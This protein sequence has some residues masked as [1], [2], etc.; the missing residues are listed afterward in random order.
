MSAGRRQK[1]LW[2]VD[3]NELWCQNM[4]I[5]ILTSVLPCSVA[6]WLVK[7]ALRT[8]IPGSHVFVKFPSLECG[9][10][11]VTWIEPIQYSQGDEM[12]LPWLGYKTLS[13][14]S[15]WQ[16]VFITFSTC[17]LSWSKLSC[18]RG[19]G[20]KELKLTSS[21]QQPARHWILS[22]TTPWEENTSPVEFSIEITVLGSTPSLQSPETC[23]DRKFS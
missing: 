1:L 4:W 14:P 18:G 9:L 6:G 2:T 15:C 22:A 12:S 3:K 21:Q 13:F 16:T 7:W 11:L 20:G 8:S 23:W 10:D 19:P 17:I 5:Q